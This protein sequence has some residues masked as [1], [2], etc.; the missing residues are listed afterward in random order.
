MLVA[1]IL[2]VEELKLRCRVPASP[3]RLNRA[4]TWC[5]PAE[6]L[7]PTPFLGVNALL[8]TTG[9]GMNI[10]DQR[11]WDAYVERL[12][13][14]PV[15]ALVFG[16]GSAHRELP[17][18]LIAACE[19][20]DIP[21]L[22]L[23][24][25][26]PFIHVMRYVEQTLSAERYSVLRQGWDIADRCTR[27]AATGAALGD[28]V[29][30]T[31][32]AADAYVAIIDRDGFELVGA[33]EPKGSRGTKSTR[34]TLRMPG[35]EDEEFRLLVRGH[36]AEAL[37][38]P[39]LGP[40]AA[41]LSMQLNN[42]LGGRTPLHSLE[43]A[44]FVEALYSPTALEPEEFANLARVAGFEAG[45]PWSVVIVRALEGA[46]KMRLRVATWRIRVGLAR[47]FRVVRFVES[48]DATT[49]LAQGH[50]GDLDL[51][52]E[53]STFLAKAEGIG[54]VVQP[55]VGAVDLALVLRIATR[56]ATQP[57]ARKSPPIDLSGI[58]ESLPNMALVNL[59]RRLL[60]PLDST[61]AHS[62]TET[63]EAYLKLGGNKTAV[64]S[65]LFIHRNTLTYRLRKIADLLE[66]DLDD[67]DVRASLLLALKFRAA[68]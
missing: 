55:D 44:R 24:P 5:A 28:L 46:T 6:H 9:M 52:S 56:H 33:G 63:L 31:A 62:L 17:Q 32:D 4:I 3:G 27:L 29:D 40:V 19:R 68:H 47:F 60:A 18:G 14:V 66:V 61:A 45:E 36:N 16:V 34:T 30:L 65:E 38:Q 20:Y 8:L 7:D 53:V 15:C 10:R 21:L 13:A 57:G 11:T 25:E 48:P 1:D 50:S 42:T 26:I 64:C 54:V 2:D 37:L 51:L 49:I 23:P 35:G 39:L 67:G 43:A 58:L 59:S 22:E 41:V 12:S